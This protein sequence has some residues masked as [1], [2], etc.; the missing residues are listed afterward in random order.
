MQRSSPTVRRIL[1]EL[2]SISVRCRHRAPLS[3]LFMRFTPEGPLGMALKD[4][5]EL[6]TKWKLPPT[7]RKP[8]SLLRP[9]YSSLT[10]DAQSRDHRRGA[11]TR[12]TAADIVSS[13]TLG[14]APPGRSRRRVRVSIRDESLAEC[15]VTHT[16][17]RPCALGEIV[18]DA[19][20]RRR[21]RIALTSSRDR[22]GRGSSVARCRRAE[23]KR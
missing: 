19:S 7:V 2:E 1:L 13:W 4:S 8:R 12:E 16:V 10:R 15:G 14:R 23:C 9:G 3:R 20:R 6:A 22:L 5:D 11:T 18:Y 21:R 17:R